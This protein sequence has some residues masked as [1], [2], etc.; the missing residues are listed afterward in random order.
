VVR[1]HVRRTLLLVSKNL[2]QQ[3]IDDALAKIEAQYGKAERVWMMDRGIPLDEV[4][5]GCARGIH[6]G[7][8]WGASRKGA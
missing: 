2:D 5:A 8:I 7:K 3:T 1:R 6:R 4:L